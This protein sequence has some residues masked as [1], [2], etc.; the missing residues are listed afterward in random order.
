MLSFNIAT[1]T[2]VYSI[3]LELLTKKI[4]DFS[5]LALGFGMYTFI[6]GLFSIGLHLFALVYVCFAI[7][8]PAPLLR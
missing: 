7:F 8:I 3:V 5:R 1:L 4:D 6:F 2:A